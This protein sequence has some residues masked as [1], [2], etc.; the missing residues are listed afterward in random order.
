M[1]DL[2]AKKNRILGNMLKDMGRVLVAFSG[3]VD[4]ALLLERAK[5]ELGD[6]VLAVVVY[7]ELFRKEEFEGAVKLAEEMGVQ[8]HQTE[9][10]ELKNPFIVANNPDSW[11]HSKKMLY[12]HLKELAKELNYHYVLDGMIMDDM[13]DFRPGLKARNEEGVRSVLQEAG[14]YKH[15]VRE[16][17][18][19]FSVP[20]W[21]KPASCSLASRIPY[22]VKLDQKKIDQVNEAELFIL[23]LGISTVR[24][25]HHGDVA[26]I[27]VKQDEISKLLEH[28]ELI[29]KKLVILGFSYVSIDLLGY[30]TGSMN[31]VLPDDSKALYSTVVSI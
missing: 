5:Q 2:L 12:S 8:V 16:L 6:Q 13:E 31:E 29:H 25:R 20:V 7:S 28:N 23:S 21:N 22:G 15:E 11:Y 18:Q 3:G 4:S 19:L 10:K 27:E 17:A 14:L 1:N 24:V 30:R 9:M 26:R